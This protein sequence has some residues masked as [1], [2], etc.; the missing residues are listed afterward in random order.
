[1]DGVKGLVVP[2]FV[3][4]ADEH[5]KNRHL[6]SLFIRTA[7][8]RRGTCSP[9][10]EVETSLTV[11]ACWQGHVQTLRN[12]EHSEVVESLVQCSESLQL[13]AINL[14]KPGMEMHLEV[15]AAGKRNLELETSPQLTTDASSTGCSVRLTETGRVVP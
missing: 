15:H 14:L 8:S 6:A 7:R 9:Q 5:R 13:P 4:L 3:L 12:C 11:G 1:M 2:P 10:L